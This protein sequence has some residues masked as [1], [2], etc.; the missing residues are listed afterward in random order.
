MLRT[1]LRPCAWLFTQSFLI[2]QACDLD[3]PRCLELLL[4]TDIPINAKDDVSQ[5]ILH[6]LYTHCIIVMISSGE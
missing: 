3:S 2:D 4:Q 6:T 1:N 5:H